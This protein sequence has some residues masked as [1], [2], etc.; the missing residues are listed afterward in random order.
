MASRMAGLTR[1]VAAQSQVKVSNTSTKSYILTSM[2]PSTYKTAFLPNTTDGDDSISPLLPPARAPNSAIE[3][4]YTALYTMVIAMI[5]LS[6]TQ[7]IP[8]AK[9]DRYLRRMNADVYMME[10]A[11][12]KKED[13]LKRMEREGYL[14]RRREVVGGEEGVDYVVGGR[15]KLEVG[16]EGVKGLVKSVYGFGSMAGDQQEDEDEAEAERRM[17]KEGDLERKLARSLGLNDNVGAKNAR[18]AENSDGVDAQTQSR[19]QHEADDRPGRRSRGRPRR[20][21]SRDDDDY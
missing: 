14:E 8:E 3:S 18:H 1:F 19:T 17:E 10:G 12:G 13:V 11:G 16:V 21:P 4:T 20:D 9:L 2:L 6:P 15:G 5:L 7:A